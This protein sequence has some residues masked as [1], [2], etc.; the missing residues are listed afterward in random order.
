MCS[1]PSM[2]QRMPESI[3]AELPK[4]NHACWWATT[5]TSEMEKSAHNQ[6]GMVD[7]QPFEQRV[8]SRKDAGIS[9]AANGILSVPF[10]CQVAV[11]KN[12]TM[13]YFRCLPV[14]VR[15]KVS[16]DWQ[17]IQPSEQ[18]QC[19]EYAIDQLS[20]RQLESFVSQ[21]FKS[22]DGMISLHVGI[23]DAITEF[24]YEKWWSI[25]NGWSKRRNGQLAQWHPS[26]LVH[27][28]IHA[29]WRIEEYVGY[30]PCQSPF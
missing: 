9:K 14:L 23:N 2:Q 17:G 5:P 24:N 8:T 22:D 6:I 29:A 18:Q 25:W 12:V 28:S 4:E 15:I 11:A 1:S 21:G 16:L 7:L 3:W 10:P 27:W 13:S 30:R 20:H 19:Y 26:S